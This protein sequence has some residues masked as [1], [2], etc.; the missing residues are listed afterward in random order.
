MEVI[1]FGNV[2][3]SFGAEKVLDD[4]SFTVQRGE[5]LC[6]LGA[7]GCGKSTTLRIIGD[8]IESYQG[9]VRVE[10]GHPKEMW[11]KISYVFQSPRLVP[12][13]NAVENVMLGMELRYDEMSR[14]RMREV[15]LKYLEIA[16]LSRDI[17]KYP[18]MLSG[19]EKQRVALA[20][21]LAVD[22]E[23]VLMDEPFSGL[24]VQTRERLRDEVIS[25]WKR[26]EKTIIFVTH[27]IEE[28]LYLAQRIVVFSRKPTRILRTIPVSAPR[29]RNLVGDPEIERLKQ[30]IR[31]MFL[32]QGW[33]E[34]EGP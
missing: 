27:D 14:S 28:A 29:P 22:P 3:I 6:L 25:I 1:E 12:W 21:A 33:T 23:I 11:N 16:G 31:A 8:L 5:F 24:D 34:R 18:I 19:G 7:S 4:V 26:T 2:M 13:R 30:E 15:A 32:D 9:M 20:R 10:G 17:H